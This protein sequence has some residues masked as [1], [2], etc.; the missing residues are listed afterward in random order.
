MQWLGHRIHPKLIVEPAVHVEH[1]P[2]DEKKR[3]HPSR[4]LRR[5]SVVVAVVA[6]R[7]V[8]EAGGNRS[9]LPAESKNQINLF[10]KP[11]TKQ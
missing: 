7:R 8:L 9:S 5:V 2:H 10:I 4:P 1:V 11:S 3:N 6:D